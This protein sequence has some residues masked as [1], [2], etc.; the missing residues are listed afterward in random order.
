M[1]NGSRQI[2]AASLSEPVVVRLTRRGRGVAWFS[3]VA[4][5]VVVVWGLQAPESAPAFFSWRPAQLIITLSALQTVVQLVI[6]QGRGLVRIGPETTRVWRVGGFPRRYRSSEVSVT[7]GGERGQILTNGSPVG[8]LELFD[9]N[10][11]FPEG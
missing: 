3:T 2:E 1:G 4:L 9:I 8:R 10:G 11:A 5:V 7:V 6:D